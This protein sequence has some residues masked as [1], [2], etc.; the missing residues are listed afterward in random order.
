MDR[1]YKSVRMDRRYK[2]V[3]MDRGYKS[4]CLS[5]FILASPNLWSQ[6][7]NRSQDATPCLIHHNR[8]HI[9]IVGPHR[10]SSKLTCGNISASKDKGNYHWKQK[11]LGLKVK[12]TNNFDQ[13]YTVNPCERGGNI[14]SK[15]CRV[16]KVAGQPIYPRCQGKTVHKQVQG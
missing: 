10:L 5:I 15:T 4:V 3:R 7:W 14:K 12:P 8:P 2:S 9:L 13:F 11:S 16:I 1:R 6:S